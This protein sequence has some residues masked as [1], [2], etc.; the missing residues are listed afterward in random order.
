MEIYI[1]HGFT[2]KESWYS[3]FSSKE[4]ALSVLQTYLLTDEFKD[5]RHE[6][7]RYNLRLDEVISF[8]SF[9]TD[10]KEFSVHNGDRENVVTI[11]LYNCFGRMEIGIA[12]L[13]MDSL[14]K[15]DISGLE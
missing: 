14:Q 5:V 7:E 12:P 1:L 3:A 15:L 6:M 2:T 13:I 4:A 11:R 10:G 9:T 8:E